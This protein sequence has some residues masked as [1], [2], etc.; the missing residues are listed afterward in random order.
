MTPREKLVTGKRGLSMAEAIS[1]L[2]THR[3]EKLPLVDPDGK[4]AG[5]ITSRDIYQ[6]KK[7]SL[8][9]ENDKGQ[10][11]VG[12]AIGIQKDWQ[13]RARA[14][15]KAGADVL[16]LDVAHGHLEAVLKVIKQF[17]KTF[18]GSDIIAGNVATS[19]A[20]ADLIKAGADGIKVGVGPGSTCITRI[21]AGAGVP[22]LTA[23]FDCA[24]A[25]KTK[26]G[27]NVPLIAD[28]GLRF[29]GD[30]TKALAAGASTVMSGFIFSGTD[31][32]PGSTTL[33]NGQKYKIYRGM[34]S[35]GA[36]LG[37]SARELRA[38]D[39]IDGLYAETAEGV[40]ALVP[41]RGTLAEALRPFVGGLRSGMSYCGARTIAE[42][43]KKAEFI[44]I[45]GAS[46]RE[47]GSHD[48]IKV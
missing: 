6:I 18:I 40:E 46:Q 20:T 38:E 27:C 8:A 41:Y 2:R 3:L 32:T 33:R 13:T 29:T 9:A 47:S 19:E 36:G 44:R 45:T 37:R 23:I 21:V 10:L 17:K 14:L 34:A 22:Q 15:L 25:A 42:L 7:H 4:L 1:L 12:A 30:I 24:K 31:E 26:I 28:G 35:L 39:E 5:L 48:V 11:I 16:V 43:H